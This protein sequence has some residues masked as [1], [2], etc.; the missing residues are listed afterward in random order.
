GAFL[1]LVTLRQTDYNKIRDDV[2]PLAGTVFRESERLLAPSRQ[3]AKALLGSVS[4]ATKDDITANP[5]TLAVG[6]F[7][8]HGGLQQRYDTRLRGTPGM[9]VVIARKSP[10]DDTVE[11][12]Q[13][14]STKAVAGVPIKTTLDVA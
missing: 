11:D 13:L 1:D 14:F 5:D 7:V 6:D 3:F 9:S 8:G 2:R 12:A 10:D 4:E